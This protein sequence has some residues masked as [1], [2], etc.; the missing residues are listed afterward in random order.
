[1]T[2]GFILFSLN[3]T[4]HHYKTRKRPLAVTYVI[5]ILA[6]SLETCSLIPQLGAAFPSVT[7]IT[8]IVTMVTT[9]IVIILNMV[10]SVLATRSN[11]IL[12]YSKLSD[13]DV[14]MSPDEVMRKRPRLRNDTLQQGALICLIFIT[15]AVL[16]KV[17]Y[18]G[19]ECANNESGQEY[20][21]ENAFL[22][23]R[24]LLYIG[25]YVQIFCNIRYL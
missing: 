10:V 6:T 22:M 13:H 16:P 7:L 18:D 9:F 17:T 25:A 4:L 19:L 3:F 14:I 1:M 12:G 20:F 8:N 5:F 21:K 24:S 11:G 2:L 23:T 15:L